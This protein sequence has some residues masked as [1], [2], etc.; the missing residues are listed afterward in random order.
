MASSHSAHKTKQALFASSCLQRPGR[1]RTGH[2]LAWQ[3]QWGTIGNRE[4]QNFS[5]SRCVSH[6]HW[7]AVPKEL[8]LHGWKKLTTSQ[9]IVFLRLLLWVPVYRGVAFLLGFCVCFAY[10]FPLPEVLLYDDWVRSSW[11]IIMERL[12]ETKLPLVQS[13][14]KW[15]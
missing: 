3:W 6:T 1:I 15:G 12:N 14:E 2:I 8:V 5:K 9:S 11:T 13:K 7:T 4:V 10:C